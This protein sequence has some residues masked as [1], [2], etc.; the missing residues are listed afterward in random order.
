M[1]G[2][3]DR[4]S[5]LVDDVYEGVWSKFASA[6]G[7][8]PQAMHK[9]KN[10]ADP[11]A[12]T[13]TAIATEANIS[14]DWLLTGQGAMQPEG[15]PELIY[16]NWLDLG[17]EGGPALGF[18]DIADEVPTKALAFRAEWLKSKGLD[19]DKLVVIDVNG[20]SMEPMINNQDAILVDTR[21]IEQPNQLAAYVVRVHDGL[22]V[23]HVRYDRTEG[24]WHL[25]S[26]NPL[27]RDLI[28]EDIEIMGKVVWRASW[29]GD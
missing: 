23:K 26:H 14:I 13:L 7:F 3:H 20:T 18:S 22:V 6:I 29:I 5:L 9:I 15:D 10:G 19:K 1:S 16:I 24:R 28:Y 17:A 4:L 27:N 11:S 2:F 12:K 25:M 8:T 21:P